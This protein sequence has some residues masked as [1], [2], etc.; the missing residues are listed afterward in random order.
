MPGSPNVPAVI[1]AKPIAGGQIG[2]TPILGRNDITSDDGNPILPDTLKVVNSQG[3]FVKNGALVQFSTDAGGVFTN[4]L[5][6]CAPSRPVPEVP[7]TDEVQT[8]TWGGRYFGQQLNAH[9]LSVT[10][11]FNGV[12][13][14]PVSLT[15]NVLGNET[16]GQFVAP[17]AAAVQKALEGMSTIGAGNI[18][19]AKNADGTYAFTFKG[20]LGVSD[21]PDITIGTW[22]TWAPYEQYARSRRPS[23]C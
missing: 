14:E 15:S 7:G 6:I 22:K 17:S 16:L 5:E 20:A 9:P 10:F 12:E 4:D 2:L 23:P 13:S 18:A 21:Q 8:L 11:K 3:G 1:D 19:V